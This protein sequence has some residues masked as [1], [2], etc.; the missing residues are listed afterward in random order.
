MFIL[1][2]SFSFPLPCS[3]CSMRLSHPLRLSLALGRHREHAQVPSSSLPSLRSANWR[4]SWCLTMVI[5]TVPPRTTSA[6]SRRGWQQQPWFHCH[7]E[8]AFNI[9]WMQ[10]IMLTNTRIHVLFQYL[11]W[12]NL[13]KKSDSKHKEWTV[14]KYLLCSRKTTLNNFIIFWYNDVI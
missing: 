12:S 2:R 11:S 13:S 4:M 9:W 5:I 10:N 7:Y 8:S 1:S 3:C 6:V 14:N